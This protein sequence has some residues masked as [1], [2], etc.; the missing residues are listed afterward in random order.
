MPLQKQNLPITLNKGVDTKTDDK[1]S[2]P[3]SLVVLE[4]GLFETINEIRKRPG[5]EVLPVDILNSTDRLDSGVTL[6]AYKNELLQTDG[7]A[8]YSFTESAQRWDNK[9]TI[10]HVD[11]ERTPVS[12]SE[13]P[14]NDSTINTNPDTAYHPIGVTCHVWDHVGSGSQ[15]SYSVIDYETKERIVDNVLVN[16]THDSSR[17]KVFTVGNYFIILFY[18]VADTVLKYVAV[19]VTNAANPGTATT[20]ASNIDTTLPNYDGVV[21]NG[22]LFVAYNNSTLGGA[23]SIKSIDDSLVLSSTLSFSGE[24]ADGCIGAVYDSTLDRIWI[25]Y[26]NA[27]GDAKRAVVTPSLAIVSSPA[28]IATTAQLGSAYV[29]NITGYI[30]NN[31]GKVFIEIYDGST[32]KT[33]LSKIYSVVVTSGTAATPALFLNSVGLMSKPFP[34]GESY[35][36]VIGF[37]STLQKTYFLVNQSGVVVAKFAPG[38][39]GGLT[40]GY[41]GT[42]QVAGSILTEVIEIEDDV[43]VFSSIESGN[44]YFGGTALV[45]NSTVYYTLDMAPE[46]VSVDAANDLHVSGGFLWMYDGT[47]PVEHNFHL[48]PENITA[49]VT[50]S[51]GYLAA[52]TYSYVF[53]WAWKDSAGQVH[54]SAPSSP[55]SVTVTSDDYV[56]FTVPTL[57]LTQKSNI[58][59]TYYRTDVDGTIYYRGNTRTVNSTTSIT[60]SIVDGLL[61]TQTAYIGNPLL[62]TTGGVV[63]NNALP[64]CSFIANFKQRVIAIPSE[65]KNL[66]YYSKLIGTGAIG[67]QAPVAFS[68]SFTIEVDSQG[69]D[70]NAAAQL[71]DKFI[72]FKDDLLMYMVGDGPADTGAQNDFSVPQLLASDVGCTFENKRSVVAIPTGLMFKSRKGIYLLDRSLQCQYI[73]APVEAFNNENIVKALLIKDKNQVRFCTDNGNTLVFDYYFN[74]WSVFTPMSAVDACLFQDEFTFLLSDGSVYQENPDVYTDNGNF[75][76]LKMVFSWLSFAGIQGF[77]RLRRLLL[78]GRY[79]TPH[80]LLVK[81]AYDFDPN[82]TQQTTIDVGELFDNAVYGADSVYGE[83]T[84]YGGDS[85]TYQFRISLAKQKCE[86]LQIT[87]EDTQESGYGQSYSLSNFALEAGVKKGLNKLPSSRTFA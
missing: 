29:R 21:V 32:N 65:F 10:V 36:F 44:N 25:L 31:S 48:Y 67:N 57:G 9:G 62:Y 23:V 61:S 84:P 74:Q 17:P 5:N 34:Y 68:S 58:Q 27:A 66:L 55:V 15:I 41:N 59:I 53:V 6:S 51:G 22:K 49:A 40:N 83:S 56:T 85:Q 72:L 63:E 16:P 52:G 80:K 30:S 18:D 75:I 77:Q 73:G 12:L 70:T 28:V 69:G 76:K 14:Q 47:L 1:Q 71:D 24:N 11:M 78:L 13:S 79:F 19:P 3:G 81:L 33:Y 60:K 39:A 26:F 46:P 50:S 82:P 4:N 54:Q 45:P 86:S 38:I 7:T 8:L 87:I 42:S 2:V 43:F 64:A 20:F 37:Q 35:Y